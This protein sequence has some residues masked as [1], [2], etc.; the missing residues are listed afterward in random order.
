MFS[1]LSTLVQKAQSFIDPHLPLPNSSDRR[2]SKAALFRH[3]FR[4]PDSQNP[5]HEITA[6]L[7]LPPK[8]SLD[9][10]SSPSK[11]SSARPTWDKN[12]WDRE[13]GAH[14]VGRLHLSEQYLCFSTTNSSFTATASTSASSTFTGHTNGAG[15]AGNGFT[16]PL[17]AVRRVERLHSQSYMFALAIST[18]NGYPAPDEKN[19][20]ALQSQ[21]GRTAPAAPKLVIQLA[22][23]RA[24]CERFCDGLKKGLREGMREVE[25]M[26][27]VLA[28]C[29]SE[30]MLAAEAK[31]R[32]KIKREKEA[33]KGTDEKK[34]GK[35]VDAGDDGEQQG[36][37]ILKPPDSGLG[38]IFR[39][40]GDA[41]KL[42]DKG[43]MRLWYEYLRGEQFC[44][45]TW[46]VKFADDAQKMDETRLSCG[47]RICLV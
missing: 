25:V 40:P 22:G 9:P 13:R 12:N 20:K 11:T 29:Y 6:E 31:R 44:W 45:S 38:S 23:S 39:Y 41:R 15:P 47:N 8:T 19:P 4:L 27:G 32:E 36:D 42:R 3:Q 7:T 21:G 28:G 46:S 10:K 1:N 16:L 34:E 35:L 18:W 2:P 26:R 37:D 14:Y 30:F 5:L 43:K 24:Q 33:D 17:C